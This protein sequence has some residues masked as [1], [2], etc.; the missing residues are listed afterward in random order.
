MSN[1]WG[2]VQYCP[3]FCFGRWAG[4]C[5]AVGFPRSAIHCPPFGAHSPLVPLAHSPLPIVRRR[6]SADRCPFSAV[7]LPSGIV[8]QPIR[9][10]ACRTTAGSVPHARNPPGCRC[11]RF[12]GAGV[13]LFSRHCACACAGRG[14]ALRGRGT[15]RR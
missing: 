8:R 11:A 5:A 3:P 13:R 14:R 1:F 15:S 7:G 12:I 10:G 9:V 6:P 4:S 2:A